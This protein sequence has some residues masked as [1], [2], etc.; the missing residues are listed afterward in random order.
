M[1]VVERAREGEKIY[2]D[3]EGYAVLER[4]SDMFEHM[5]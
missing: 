5:H 3:C 2:G 4:L 1:G